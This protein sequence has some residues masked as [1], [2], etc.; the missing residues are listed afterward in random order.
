MTATLQLTDQKGA[1]T[2]TDIASYLNNQAKGNIHLV[3]YVGP[4]K[5]MLNVYSVILI[6]PAWKSYRG[7]FDAAMTFEQYLVSAEGQNLFGTF[8]VQGQTVFKPWIPLKTANT[9]TTTI[10]WIEAYAYINGTDCPEKYRVN[11]GD[12]YK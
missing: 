10:Q 5:D 7:T 11:A 6:N 1:Y 4:G 12:L 2:L 8:G 9:D 3:Q